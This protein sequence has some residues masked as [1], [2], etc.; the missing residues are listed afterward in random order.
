[1]NIG[2]SFFSYASLFIAYLPEE[3]YRYTTIWYDPTILCFFRE[4]DPTILCE[5]EIRPRDF[6]ALPFDEYCDIHMTG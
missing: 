3:S 2:T 4:R 5:Y 1:M 6:V